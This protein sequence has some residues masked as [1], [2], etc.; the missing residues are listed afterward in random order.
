MIKQ[1]AWCKSLIVNGVK[2]EKL[3]KLNSEMSHGICHSCKKEME[4]D[5]FRLKS[6]APANNIN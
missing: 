6:M 4:M 1:C 3:N 5:F 2:V